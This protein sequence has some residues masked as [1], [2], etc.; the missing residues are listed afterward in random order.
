MLDVAGPGGLSQFHRVVFNFIAAKAIRQKSLSDF[1]LLSRTSIGV[2]NAIN[3]YCNYRYIKRLLI[4]IMC[5][6]QRPS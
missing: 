4:A 5:G 3:K 1:C 2:H 6:N